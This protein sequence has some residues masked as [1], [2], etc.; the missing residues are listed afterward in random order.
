MTV[1]SIFRLVLF[2]FKADQTRC[3]GQ[4]YGLS[5]N[6]SVTFS[7]SERTGQCCCKFWVAFQF[8]TAMVIDHSP[9]VS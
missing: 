4:R 1:L 9:N 7:L 2:N 8:K 6:N 3:C 5:G